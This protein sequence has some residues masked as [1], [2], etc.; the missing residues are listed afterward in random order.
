MA[1]DY[2]G[3][4]KKQKQMNNIFNLTIFLLLTGCVAGA[5][6]LTQEQEQRIS[7][8]KIFKKDNNP[9]INYTKLGEAKSADCSGPGGS[10]LYGD[11]SKSIDILIKKAIVLGADAIIEVDCSGVPYVNNCWLAQV[12]DGQAIKWN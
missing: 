9:S 5:P 8:V 6:T 4:T 12:C 1:T 2:I 11:K 10:R 3:V 7:E